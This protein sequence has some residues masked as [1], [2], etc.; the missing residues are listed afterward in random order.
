MCLF[1]RHQYSVLY[2][3]LQQIVIPWTCW[4]LVKMHSCHPPDSRR[5]NI[6]PF[7]LLMLMSLVLNH[8]NSCHTIQGSIFFHVNYREVSAPFSV[9]FWQANY[10]FTPC[11]HPDRIF[12]DPLLACSTGVSPPLVLQFLSIKQN[13]EKLQ[14]IVMYRYTIRL[15]CLPLM[16]LKTALE[17]LGICI[18]FC[19]Y[20]IWFL[21]IYVFRHL[22]NSHQVQTGFQ[23]LPVSVMDIYTLFSHL[24]SWIPFLLVR[25]L[26][27][28]KLY[29]INLRTLLLLI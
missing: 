21:K 17:S 5:I 22:Q 19:S 16:V 13:E 11:P 28:Q 26:I 2:L 23:V 12:C 1:I 27:I 18:T 29:G 4:S 25:F 3:K 8:P 6:S 20:I 9:Y 7:S 15:F 14:K 24:A 10:H